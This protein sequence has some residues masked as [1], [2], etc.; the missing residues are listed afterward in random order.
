MISDV[1]FPRVNGVSTSIATSRDALHRMGHRTTLVAPDYPGHEETDRD[2]VRVD[3]FRIPFDPEDY[4]MRRRS[5]R[6]TTAALQT[7]DFDIVHIHTPFRAHRFGVML[8]Q[9]L[10]I[11]AIETYHTHFEEYVHHYIPVLP[12]AAGRM[13]ARAVARRIAAGVAA[14]VVPSLAMAQ[15]LRSYGIGIPLHV[16]PTGLVLDEFSRGGDR[17]AFC[18][19]FDVDPQRLSMVYVGRV[20]FE[21]NVGVLLD[22]VDRVRQAVPDILLI[23]AGEGPARRALE[24]RAAR[25]GLQRNVLFVG[26]LSRGRELWDCFC[27]GD[28]FVFPSKTET[29]G[30]VLLEAMAL[31]VPVAGY[32]ELGAAEILTGRSGGV[33]V[34]GDAQSFA[35]SVLE[36]LRDKERRTALSARGLSYAREWSAREMTRRM[37]DVYRDTIA[38]GV[39]RAAVLP[40]D[41]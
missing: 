15:S 6:R 25:M 34:E 33:A 12:R 35:D 13:F 31:G 10:G 19:R 21:K 32:A 14:F 22:T 2:V 11:P 4:L 40:V 20:A 24:A 29:Q 7:Q 37:L 26:Y 16:V 39:S 18:D 17:L 3:A 30:L 28:I 27:A 5:L 41:N 36:L 8:S 23:I 9:R 1:Y 38:P